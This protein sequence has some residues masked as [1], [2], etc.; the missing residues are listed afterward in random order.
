MSA[1][2]KGHFQHRHRHRY[3]KPK[4]E[5]ASEPARAPKIT[6]ALAGNPNV[7]KSTIFSR[8]TNSA[9]LTANYPGKTLAANI[10]Y[11]QLD[12]VRIRWVDLPGAYA[13]G[14]ISEDQREARRALLR[15]HPQAVIVAVD[16]TNLAR[17]L[18]LVLELLD[19]DF[20]VVI[21]LNLVDEA[22]RRGLEIDTQRLSQLLGTPVVPTVA[23]RGHGLE[24]LTR[25][26]LSLAQAQPTGQT[27]V[28][29]QAPVADQ[30]QVGSLGPAQPGGSGQP[31]GP[32]S[33]RVVY[34]PQL[35]QAIDAIVELLE[36]ARPQ[37]LTTL[38]PSL[39][40]AALLLWERDPE[41]EAAFQQFP[42]GREIL[43]SI[44]PI[45]EAAG[46]DANLAL[47]KERYRLARNIA[48]QVIR[49]NGGI[50]PA[51]ASA[52]VT[53]PPDP[54]SAQGFWPPDNQPPATTSIA[55]GAPAPAVPAPD[56]PDKAQAAWPERLWHYTTAPVSGLAI[57]VGVIATIFLTLF[58]LG[59]A[60]SEAF[61]WFWASFI[62][63]LLTGAFHALFGTGLLSQVLYWGIDAGIQ[64]AL[65]VGIPYILTFYVLLGLLEDTGYLNSVAFLADRLMHYLGLD[66]RAAIPLAAAAGCNVPAIMGTQVLPDMR[67]RTIASTLITLI[68]CNAR[69]A[70]IIGAVS[71][72]LGWQIALI[73][74][75][76]E[77]LLVVSVGFILARMLP[78]QAQGMILE[79]FPFRMPTL[80][81]TWQKTWMRFKD[82]LFIAMP[83][84]LAG[85]A[86]LGLLYETGWIWRLT[87][88]LSPVIEGWLG[89]PGVA[90]LTLLF[91]IL[92]KEMAIQFL[93]VLATVQYGSQAS[94]LLHF[95]TPH[96]LIVY[97]V[98]TIIYVPCVATIAALWRELGA[99]RALGISLSTIALALAIGTLLHHLGL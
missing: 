96:Q 99:K 66:G 35:R 10:A 58:F 68:P 18:Y 27:Q 36:Q 21:A 78:G 4:A 19:M 64:S 15:E 6:I 42:Q 29:A 56:N 16:A 90:G 65:A 8:L 86:G 41:V 9:V 20:P 24:E 30:A 69:L 45:I 72:Y 89:L 82:Y 5:T 40:T 7:G 1:E 55:P 48:Q 12:G 3:G 23:V 43:A 93:V 77:M 80:R 51:E 25:A 79:L 14:G 74:L 61:T 57:L 94:N 73:I 11:S 31:I 37:T 88:P 97:A 76:G 67:S 63:P 26:A 46:A 60:L 32:P 95:M 70:V 28:A 33:A 87:D 38:R 83:I 71:H 92:R 85:S 62:S 52:A 44:K 81:V 59:N 49:T 22:S 17:N 39:R 2:D 47:I 53:Q 98:V 50:N 34:S 54:A 13:L 75:M 84:I 91:A